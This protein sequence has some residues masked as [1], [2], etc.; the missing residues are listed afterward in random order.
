MVETTEGNGADQP[1]R[2]RSS[3]K[4]DPTYAER[5]RR[6]K[7]KRKQKQLAVT[8]DA[9]PGVTSPPGNGVTCLRLDGRSLTPFPH[10]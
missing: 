5:Q 3:K 6:F 9:S 2:A 7:Q 8:V 10:P 4:A 1:R